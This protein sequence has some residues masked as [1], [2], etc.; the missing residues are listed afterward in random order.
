[1]SST[2]DDDRPSTTIRSTDELL[3]VIFIRH[4]RTTDNANGVISGGLADP[5]LVPEGRE[6]AKEAHKVYTALKAKGIVNDGTPVFTTDRRR[7]V[8]T[9]KL[10]TGRENGENF[11]IDPRL[12]ERLLGDWDSKLTERLQKEIKAIPGFSPPTEEKPA[13]HKAHVFECLDQRIAEA[14]GQPIII[15]S[16]GGTTRRIA[17]YFGIDEGLE[18]Q[19]AVPHHAVSNDGGKSWELKRFR[20][21]V[22]GQLQEEVLPKKLVKVASTK[23][24]MESI[25]V[26]HAPRTSLSTTDHVLTITIENTTDTFC[27]KEG[28]DTLADDLGQLL[29]GRS[30]DASAVVVEGALVKVKLDSLQIE[31]LQQYAKLKGIEFADTSSVKMKQT[32][33]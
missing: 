8:D 3:H 27:H 17:A 29:I 7:A 20:V 32:K 5:E 12:L 6:Q 19:N 23:R 2:D 10:F 11:T 14:R 16:H 24:T 1:M 26:E 22:K 9:A 31:I 30:Y 13:D 18:V 4:G 33:V 21:D 28:I 15:V 25:L